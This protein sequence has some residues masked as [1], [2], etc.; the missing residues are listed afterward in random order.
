MSL[1]EV[2]FRQVATAPPRGDVA[3]ELE[4]D[5]TAPDSPA[6]FTGGLWSS[7]EEP[8]EPAV[9]VDRPEYEGAENEVAPIPTFANLRG[10]VRGRPLEL[11]RCMDERCRKR[12]LD[13]RQDYMTLAHDQRCFK[14]R[15]QRKAAKTEELNQAMAGH[16]KEM[17]E[18]LKTA[19][20][21]LH[22]CHDEQQQ[23]LSQLRALCG[24]HDRVLRRIERHKN[25]TAAFEERLEADPDMWAEPDIRAPEIVELDSD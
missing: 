24:V 1:T 3:E 9:L 15:L 17:T 12:S 21:N 2:D 6:S 5:P 7:E 19:I 11:N 23:G 10:H 8:P 4:I 22:G 25:D 16:L 14:F 18:T 13:I 20:T